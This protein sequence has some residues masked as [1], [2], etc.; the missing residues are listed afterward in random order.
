MLVSSSN[1]L[2]AL[3]T[4][5]FYYT[6]ADKLHKKKVQSRQ[7]RRILPARS[8]EGSLFDRREFEPSLRSWN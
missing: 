6:K 8:F 2:G 4:T 7:Y 3:Q 1:I 5:I